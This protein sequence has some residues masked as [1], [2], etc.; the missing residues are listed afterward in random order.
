MSSLSRSLTGG[1]GC[2][3]GLFPAFRE[4]HG[5]LLGSAHTSFVHV[6]PTNKHITSHDTDARSNQSNDELFF[7]DAAKLQTLEMLSVCRVQWLLYVVTQSHCCLLTVSCACTQVNT[8]L[9]T[10]YSILTIVSEDVWVAKDIHAELYRSSEF[11]T[12][13]NAFWGSS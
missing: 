7:H 3:R 6:R 11:K 5:F 10:H 12:T 8:V 9:N 4:N 13:H 1:F 2:C